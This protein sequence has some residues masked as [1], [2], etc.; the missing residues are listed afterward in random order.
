MGNNSRIDWGGTDQ[1]VANNMTAYGGKVI[2]AVEAVARYFAPILE[3]YSKQNASWEDRTGN[4]RASLY[5]YVLRVANDIVELYLSH[6]VF[7]GRYL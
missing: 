3:S 1:T 7:Y 5:S 4:A 2:E 6:G